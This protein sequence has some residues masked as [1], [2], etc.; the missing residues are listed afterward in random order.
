[1]KGFAFLTLIRRYLEVWRYCWTNRH[2]EKV[3]FFNKQEAEFLPSV[4]SLQENPDSPTLKWTARILMMLVFSAL[5]WAIV[6]KVD[7]VVNA[8]GKIIPSS[9]TKTIAS[10]EIASVKAIHVVEGQHVKEGD[11]LIELN[12]SSSDSEHD[13]ASDMVAQAILQV[14]LSQTFIKSIDQNQLLPFPFVSDVKPQQ[15][16]EAKRHLESQYQEF[17]A[18]LT[19]INSDITHF[20]EA[21]PLAE[22]RAKDYKMLT[23]EQAV[24]YHAFMEKEQAKIDLQAQLR[25]AYHRREELI[26]QTRREAQRTIVDSNKIIESARQDQRRSKEHSQLL[27]LS[28]PV[29]GTVQQLTTY[30]VGGI[31]PAAEPLMRIVPK[32]HVIEVEAFLE[33]K[34]IGFVQ[35]GQ[36][37]DIKIQAFDYAKYGTIKGRVHHVSKDAIQDEKKGWVYSVKLLLFQQGLKVENDYKWLSPG[38]SV[39]VE[40]KTGSRR[41]IEYLLSPLAKHG[42]ES[43]RER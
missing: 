30:T 15:W 13:K 33:N 25:D 27:R 28:S 16:Q 4:L 6:G 2:R 8:E 14:L 3:D 18:K 5:I 24:S 23:E 41:V 26:M 37:A 32:D 7:I 21:L 9:R 42:H 34:D 22:R 29:E 11:L 43:L 40:I 12:S 17:Q 36:M 1:M 31:V 19:R 10:I 20:S 35:V 38:M 39:G